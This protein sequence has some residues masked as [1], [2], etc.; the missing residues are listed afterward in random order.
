MAQSSA[1]QDSFLNAARKQQARVSIHV[2]NGFQIKSAKILS[3][4][5][6]VLL[7]E[8]GGKQMLVFKHAISSIT[9]EEPI[10]INSIED[11]GDVE[12]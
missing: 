1:V 10:V 3:F 11:R 12:K 2:T 5:S 8:S 7:L 9:P 4:D 6:F